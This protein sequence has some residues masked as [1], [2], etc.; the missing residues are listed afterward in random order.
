MAQR[1]FANRANSGDAAEP[2]VRVENA[3]ASAA[4]RRQVV[5]VGRQPT[6]HRWQQGVKP[7]SG[8]RIFSRGWSCRIKR[9]VGQAH[10]PPLRGL[11][12]CG[13]RFP[14]ADAHG[15]VRS[16]LARLEFSDQ[17]RIGTSTPAAATR[18][19]LIAVPAFR[20]L[21]PHGYIRSPLTRLEFSGQTQS[22][23]SIPVAATRLDLI[24][25]PAYRGLTPTATF[26]RR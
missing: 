15:Y 10:L 1:V 22:E 4:E 20:G 23:T 21:T 16:P 3:W 9:R 18:L 8:D 13:N 5:A 7:R 17:T 12:C 26:C 14:W 6:D 11:I 25:A 2:L 24:A 19:D